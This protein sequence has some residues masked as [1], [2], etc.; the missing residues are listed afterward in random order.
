MT[1]SGRKI[2]SAKMP[3]RK[4]IIGE[5]LREVDLYKKIL[6]LKP[7]HEHT[8]VQ[9]SEIL[10]SLGRYADARASAKELAAARDATGIAAPMSASPAGA[11]DSLALPSALAYP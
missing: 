9:V 6:K 5:Q 3:A 10:G 2:L 11:L 4:L 1:E 8:L 7:D